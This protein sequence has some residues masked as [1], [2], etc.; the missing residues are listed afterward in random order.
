MKDPNKQVIRL[1]SIPVDA[2]DVAAP[3]WRLGAGLSSCASRDRFAALGMVLVCGPPAGGAGSLVSEQLRAACRS[4]MQ[5]PASQ[6]C[7]AR[8]QCRAALRAVLAS[9][10]IVR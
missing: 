4:Y 1:Y 6:R 7:S 10:F 3:R 9:V 5:R 2:F 8:V